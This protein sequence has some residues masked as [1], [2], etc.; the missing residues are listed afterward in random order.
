MTRPVLNHNLRAGPELSK[1]D[2]TISRVIAVLYK[3]KRCSFA[4]KNQTAINEK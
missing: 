2:N 1:I 3:L 4:R